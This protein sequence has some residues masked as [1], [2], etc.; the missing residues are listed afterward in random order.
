MD[1]FDDDRQP[2]ELALSED[3]LRQ[4]LND[5]NVRKCI[6]LVH[7]AVSQHSNHIY[8]VPFFRNYMNLKFTYLANDQRK[9]LLKK[10]QQDDVIQMEWTPTSQPNGGYTSFSL[11]YDNPL[12][13]ETLGPDAAPPSN[14]PRSSAPRDTGA[15][16]ADPRTAYG[17]AY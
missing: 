16:Y 11:N 4:H 12:V 7:E 3:E 1:E 17:S 6:R 9:E 5:Y 10:L 15:R 14:R 2:E 8:L 13:R